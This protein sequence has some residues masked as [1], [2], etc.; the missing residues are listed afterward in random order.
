MHPW[1]SR[2]ICALQ[3]QLLARRA[4]Q[5]CHLA[6]CWASGFRRGKTARG[7]GVRGASGQIF[8]ELF[9][10]PSG[11]ASAV[12]IMVEKVPFDLTLHTSFPSCSSHFCSLIT[13]A[14]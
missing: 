3:K 1:G 2:G 5:F 10:C 6:W 9:A 4:G 7:S 12:Q 8:Q 14:N 13:C 11:L